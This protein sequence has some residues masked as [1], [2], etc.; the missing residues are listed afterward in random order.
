[1]NK[2]SSRTTNTVASSGLSVTGTVVDRTRRMVPRDN[3]TTEIVTYTIHDNC[4]HKFF[5]DDYAPT[6]YHEIDTIVCLPVYV[7]TYM[8][9]NGDLSY[10]LNVQKSEVGR[11]EHF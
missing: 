4:S 7:K 10:T 8:K 11:G 6:D 2:R 1:M 9:K 3:P 5:V